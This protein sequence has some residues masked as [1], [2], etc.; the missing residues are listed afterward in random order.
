[1]HV[2][3][4]T[5]ALGGEG[6][7]LQVRKGDRVRAGDL[8]LRFDLE[9]VAR[10]ARSL[11]TPVIVTNG[12]RFRVLRAHVDR[13][14]AAGDVLFELEEH[15]A[16]AGGARPAA[17]TPVVSEA[18]VVAHAHGIHARPAALIAR[19]RQDAAL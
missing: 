15:G 9:R 5:V 11:I 12:E 13:A 18:V 10:K 14:V 3:I 4:D 6:F 8:L 17:A 7:T 16:A 19:A 2:G 1:M